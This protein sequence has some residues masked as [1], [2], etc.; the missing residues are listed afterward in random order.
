MDDSRI[1]LEK[2]ED[3][4]K[5]EY[6]F[7]KIALIPILLSAGVVWLI[8]GEIGYGYITA[9]L[10]LMGWV[11]SRSLPKD[12]RLSKKVLFFIYGM[13]AGVLGFI[14]FG[15]LTGSARGIF[16]SIRELLNQSGEY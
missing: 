15:L 5:D 8:T 6:V 4:E 1:P 13:A 14:V 9:F 3:P 16:E 2:P 11:L 7:E 12:S 10:V